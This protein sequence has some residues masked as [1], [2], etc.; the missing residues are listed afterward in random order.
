MITLL[1]EHK[2]MLQYY[3]KLKDFPWQKGLV[4]LLKI[5]ISSILNIGLLY[6]D[7]RG[8]SASFFFQIANLFSENVVWEFW[9]VARYR[10]AYDYTEL[11]PLELPLS[12]ANEAE[13]KYLY[14]LF[15]RW[16]K[17]LHRRFIVSHTSIVRIR[18]NEWLNVELNRKGV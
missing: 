13:T 14:L 12:F 16:M 2:S 5:N 17:K 9:S 7:R 15:K 10:F 3:R 6:C 11:T 4:R 18:E 1:I 8:N